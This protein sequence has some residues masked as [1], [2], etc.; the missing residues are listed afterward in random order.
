[1]ARKKAAGA[2]GLI[3]NTLCTAKYMY[4]WWASPFPVEAPCLRAISYLVRY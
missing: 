1:M 2:T 3:P 4:I